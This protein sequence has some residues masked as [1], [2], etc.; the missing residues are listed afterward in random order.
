MDTSIIYR[1]NPNN[2]FM[3]LCM[4]IYNYICMHICIYMCMYVYIYIYVYV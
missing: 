3:L 2:I 4:T 1:V